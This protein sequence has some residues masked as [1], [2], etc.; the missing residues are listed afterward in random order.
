MAESREMIPQGGDAVALAAFQL[1]QSLVIHLIDAN[2]LTR[3]AAASILRDGVNSE[4][5]TA[6]AK[7]N[8]TSDAAAHILEIFARM[9]EKKAM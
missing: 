9:I 8:T 7:C 3:E 2:I 4:L 1:A 6:D 5:R